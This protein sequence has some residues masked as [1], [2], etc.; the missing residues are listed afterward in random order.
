MVLV[1]EQ[2]GYVT[3]F[4]FAAWH[5]QVGG[6]CIKDNLEWLTWSTDFDW[7][8]VLSLLKKY[9]QNINTQPFKKFLFI[10]IPYIHVVG[11]WFSSINYVLISKDLTSNSL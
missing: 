3:E 5:P 6:S 8:V 10:L 2:A 7:A 9:K 4:T 1:V 11:Q